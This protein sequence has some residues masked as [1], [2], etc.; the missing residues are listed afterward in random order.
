MSQVNAKTAV[1][2]FMFDPTPVLW[3]RPHRMQSKGCERNEDCAEI[4]GSDKT[5]CGRYDGMCYYPSTNLKTCHYSNIGK[6]NKTALINLVTALQE[7]NGNYSTVRSRT[8]N[9]ALNKGN[10]LYIYLDG[11]DGHDA[12]K[13]TDILN[14]DDVRTSSADD[15]DEIVQEIYNYFKRNFTEGKD[16]YRTKK[17]GGPPPK[18][19]RNNTRKKNIKP[20][21]RLSKR[22]SNLSKRR[23]KRRSRLSKRRS[24]YN[25][26]LI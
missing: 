10:I 2:F 26:I 14:L 7:G 24:K 17:G 8:I 4:T 22:R 15:I 3:E 9:T 21:S 25:N 5:Y 20:R 16:G 19:N 1:N 18:K 12:V 13:I 23:N 6:V 11:M